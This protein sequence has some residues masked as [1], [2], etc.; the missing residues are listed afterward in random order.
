MTARST[1]ILG[2]LLPPL[3][4]AALLLVPRSE[5]ASALA[6]V[7][8]VLCGLLVGRWWACLSPAT[9][10]VV[11]NGAELL[12]AR[13]ESAITLDAVFDP[14]FLLLTLVVSTALSLLGVVLRWGVTALLSAGRAHG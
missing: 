6:P 11:L 3:T 14:Q 7:S 13:H 10:A 5:L 4:V 8:F 9:V 1:A 2:L 12:G